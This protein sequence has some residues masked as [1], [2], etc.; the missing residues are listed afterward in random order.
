[1]EVISMESKA[2]AA[3][4][5]KLEAIGK[6]VEESRQR[7]LEQQQGEEEK[8]RRKGGKWMTVSIR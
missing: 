4:M 5:E 2:F 6:Y 8:N 3:L 7:E 1:M